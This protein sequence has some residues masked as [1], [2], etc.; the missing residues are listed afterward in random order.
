MVKDIKLPE[1]LLTI[2]SNCTNLLTLHANESQQSRQQT[3][4]YPSMTKSCLVDR[5]KKRLAS[6]ESEEGEYDNRKYYN[7]AHNLL[8][9]GAF[10]H[11]PYFIINLTDLSPDLVIELYNL[12][13]RDRAFVL[14]QAVGRIFEDVNFDIYHN[15]VSRALKVML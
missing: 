6:I 8:K 10:K 4:E 13:D 11:V 3:I 5:V 12:G 1:K 15:S 7:Q 2:D 14:K 9:I